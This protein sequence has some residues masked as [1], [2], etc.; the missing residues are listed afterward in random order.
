MT[1]RLPDEG[2]AKVLSEARVLYLAR[3]VWWVLGYL[4]GWP[5]VS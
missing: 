2:G 3:V 5:R 4:R 1:L